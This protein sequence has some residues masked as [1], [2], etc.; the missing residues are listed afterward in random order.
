MV[1]CFGLAAASGA[2]AATVPIRED[3]CLRG[4][5]PAELPES[6]PL[7]AP[8]RYDMGRAV[9]TV[10]APDERNAYVVQ[11][12]HSVSGGGE[13]SVAK[14][15]IVQERLNG[16]DPP[17]FASCVSNQPTPD[18]TRIY[19][20]GAM[21]HVTSAVM[22]PDGQN[23]YVAS[24]SG[25]ARFAV[26]ASGALR[27]AECV[28]LEGGECVRPTWSQ[29]ELETQ[30]LAMA[31]D[32]RDLYLTTEAR[33]REIALA[34]DG[35]M[36]MGRCYRFRSR[37]PWGWASW[38]DNGMAAVTPDGR[39]L[40]NV[41]SNRQVN[42]YKRQPDGSLR[43]TGC[44]AGTEGACPTIPAALALRDVL[45]IAVA[46]NG[47]DVYVTEGDQDNGWKFGST[48]THLRLTAAGSLEYAGCVGVDV[49]GCDR[50]PAQVGPFKG[51]EIAGKTMVISHDGSRLAVSG[52]Q[53][54]EVF[55]IDA[56]TGNL[57][58]EGCAGSEPLC[59]P[60]KIEA[61]GPQGGTLEIAPTS[62]TVWLSD[63]GDAARLRLGA[64][65]PDEAPPPA[66]GPATASVSG[67]K[68]QLSG[69]APAPG[70]NTTFYFL[71]EGAD[72]HAFY[73]K[74]KS[75]TAEAGGVRLRSEVQPPSRTTYRYRLISRD[76]AGTSYGPSGTFAVE[77]CEAGPHYPY[78]EDQSEA[79]TP[80]TLLAW[81]S[82]V[83]NCL[84][85]TLKLEY[86][87]TE[88]L[89]HVVTVPSSAFF[90]GEARQTFYVEATGLRPEAVYHWRLT[91][92]N[93]GGSFVYADH[94]WF[95]LPPAGAGAVE[96]HAASSPASAEPGGAVRLAGSVWPGDTAVSVTA[97]VF[98]EPREGAEPI[99][100]VALG[101]LAASR[102]PTA[103]AT[104]VAGLKCGR[105]YDWR[106]VASAPYGK[107]F[108]AREEF[109]VPCP[110]E[111]VPT[112]VPGEK[113][114]PEPGTGEV[115]P[116][117]IPRATRS[118]ANPLG[119]TPT[120]PLPGPSSGSQANEISVAHPS[121]PAIDSLRLIRSHGLPVAV[122]ARLTATR[123][124]LVTLTLR[125]MPP[126]GTHGKPITL[127]VRHVSV[128]P[129][130]H[131]LSVSVAG[132]KARRA[133][134]AH[135]SWLLT[136]WEK[137]TVGAELERLV[138]TGPPGA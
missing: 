41:M 6:C 124:Q 1:V 117:P 21:F 74:P 14:D 69:W 38:E 133:L 85:T 36:S 49:P 76:V 91:A 94:V 53:A 93:S 138:S 5:P 19:S 103:M 136:L 2:S 77:P 120:S 126:R 57:T 28:G 83:T 70:P 107:S 55:H 20:S 13:Y 72:G 119:P 129:G 7:A 96:M 100:T 16:S 80:T 12:T 110:G 84:P 50:L 22:A 86:G 81:G 25:V 32:G 15:T 8:S 66:P 114:M 52:N 10:T 112:P 56:P 135:R 134:R 44:L 97:E 128:A 73:A 125:L 4:E 9:V 35:A 99:D 42:A 34:P 75:E 24:R 121:L 127:G 60:L 65:V 40:V 37:C 47:R 58:W 122:V 18:C 48:I 11:Q 62:N 3:A 88:A 68:V 26:E 63:A 104:S 87:E 33:L 51:I 71:L 54:V 109:K 115:P 43:F 82:V 64:T 92:Q 95:T 79:V 67:Q 108:G 116:V 123:R 17:A 111:E 106:L 137:S 23:L 131:Y 46:P 132:D 113:A 27:F 45:S 89:G 78:G 102:E 59:E 98:D 29:G 90:L 39:W 105:Y 31:P 61:I 118:S 130:V 30:Q 101:E